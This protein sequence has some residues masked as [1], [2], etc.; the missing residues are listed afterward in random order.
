VQS[1]PTG[2]ENFRWNVAKNQDGKMSVVDLNPTDLETEPNP[3]YDPNTDIFFLLFTRQNPTVGQRLS[4]DLNTVRN[5][6]W[7]PNNAVRFV[8]HGWTASSDAIF[9]I[10]LREEF[11]K[12]ADHN[13]VI[14]DWS[15]GMIK[16]NIF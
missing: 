9:N 11:L 5:S 13:V 3:T 16:K 14:I 4:F 7:N 6:N 1:L 10:F 12:V 2:D 8:V 15:A